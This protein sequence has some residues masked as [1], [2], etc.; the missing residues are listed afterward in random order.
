M[1]LQLQHMGGNAFDTPLQDG[2]DCFEVFRILIDGEPAFDVEV[3]YA[4]QKIGAQMLQVSEVGSH[5]AFMLAHI[6][7]GIMLGSALYVALVRK[8]GE[9]DA[10]FYEELF[11]DDEGGSTKLL[12]LTIE[13]DGRLVIGD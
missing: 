3:V 5:S 12:P 9:S 4:T 10:E 13:N 7:D 2:D 8:L 1:Q 11:R 6:A